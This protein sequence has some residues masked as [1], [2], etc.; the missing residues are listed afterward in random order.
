MA[1]AALQSA[2][3]QYKMCKMWKEAGEANTQAA[4]MMLKA[5]SAHEAISCYQTAATCF[6]KVDNKGA[7]RARI[8]LPISTLAER[9]CRPIIS[10]LAILSRMRLPPRRQPHT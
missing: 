10:L 4:D 3:N 7:P 9:T 1:C 5:D 6:K 8:G 2:G